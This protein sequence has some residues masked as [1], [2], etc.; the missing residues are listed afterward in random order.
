MRKLPSFLLS[1]LVM[2]VVGAALVPGLPWNGLVAGLWGGWLAR[3]PRRALPAAL[4]AAGLLVPVLARWPAGPFP[5]GWAPGWIGGGPPGVAPLLMA[6]ALL[7]GALLGS[8]AAAGAHPRNAPSA[9]ARH[10]RT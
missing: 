9:W 5:V 7:L 6:C 8:S 1:T 3:S 4:L 10:R 2:A